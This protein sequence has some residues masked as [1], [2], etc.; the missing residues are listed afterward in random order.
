MEF[1][2]EKDYKK[3]GGPPRPTGYEGAVQ[4]LQY[5]T[6]KYEHPAELKALTGIGPT[7]IQR[8]TEKLEVYCERKGV[9][10][11]EPPA[12]KGRGSKSKD[13]STTKTKAATKASNTKTAKRKTP[14]KKKKVESESEEDEG[15]AQ[16]KEEAEAESTPPPDPKSKSRRAPKAVGSKRKYADVEDLQ[17]SAPIKTRKTSRKTAKPRSY[18]DDDDD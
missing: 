17:E 12:K 8:L 15:Q 10:M 7:T 5:C 11:P 14:A 3:R 6:T 16:E 4:A 13:E 9:A 2:A 1:H 18:K